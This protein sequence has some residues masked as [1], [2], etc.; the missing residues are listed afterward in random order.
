M[1]M[2]STKISTKPHIKWLA[3]PLLIVVG[4]GVGA[5]KQNIVHAQFDIVQSIC[6]QDKPSY[7]AN[8]Q[9]PGGDYDVYVRFG[10]LSDNAQAG[11]S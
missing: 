11:V 4:V 7:Q 2:V 8:G 10:R 1:V 3:I 6:S 9:L 5:A